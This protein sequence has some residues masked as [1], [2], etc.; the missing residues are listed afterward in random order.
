MLQLT[1]QAEYLSLTNKRTCL[2]V[3]TYIAFKC[4]V[5]LP[6]PPSS[7]LLGKQEHLWVSSGRGYVWVTLLSSRVMRSFQ[8]TSFCFTRATPTECVTLRLPISMERPTWS[9]GRWPLDQWN[10]E[11]RCVLTAIVTL[12][13]WLCSSVSHS[14]NHSHLQKNNSNTTT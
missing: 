4:D 10:K 8:Q 13:Q 5:P 12:L 2:I 1:K 14:V 3:N 11:M 7:F 6:P 9:R